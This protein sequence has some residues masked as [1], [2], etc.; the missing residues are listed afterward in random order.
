[1][2][3]DAHDHPKKV[4]TTT[5]FLRGGRQLLRFIDSRPMLGFSFDLATFPAEP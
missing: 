3:R 1:M 4:S 2:G 5:L